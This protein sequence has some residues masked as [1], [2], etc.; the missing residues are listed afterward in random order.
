[1]NYYKIQY[2][3]LIVVYDELDLPFGEIRVR[4]EGSSAGHNGIKSIMEYISSDK[5]N[6]VRIGVRN[7]SKEKMPAD[8]FV[9][10]KL[11]FFEKRKMK[12]EILP[13]AS[14]EIVKLIK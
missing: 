14:D 1:M 2:E 5:F 8:K 11:S 13:G 12:K 7:S 9:L 3:N 4:S 10:S 6:R